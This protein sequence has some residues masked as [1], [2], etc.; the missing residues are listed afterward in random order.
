MKKK[1]LFPVKDENGEIVE[2]EHVYTNKSRGS[3]MSEKQTSSESGCPCLLIE[4]CSYACTCRNPTMS[5][6][7]ERCCRY[8]S[9]SQ[10]TAKAKRLAER[11]NALL[12]LGLKLSEQEQYTSKVCDKLAEVSAERADLRKE[13][14]EFRNGFY[15]LAFDRIHK[16]LNELQQAYNELIMAVGMKF[17]NETRHQTALKYIQQAENNTQAGSEAKSALQSKPRKT[18][19]RNNNEPGQN[20]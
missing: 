6:G 20:L 12:D 14:E 8:G 19:S 5:G 13:N 11:A 16:Q 9:L 17:P 2:I 18:V 3:P 15:S 7:C 10:R 1:T 4:P